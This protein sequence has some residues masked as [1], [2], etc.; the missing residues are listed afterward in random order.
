MV[1]VCRWVCL[2]W[3]CAPAALST[4]YFESSELCLTAPFRFQGW[5]LASWMSG[6][7]S[8]PISD[9]WASKCSVCGYALWLLVCLCSGQSGWWYCRVDYCLNWTVGRS[10]FDLVCQRFVHL[11]YSSYRFLLN[12]LALHQNGLVSEHSN[13]KGPRNETVRATR[14]STASYRT[15]ASKSAISVSVWAYSVLIQNMVV[16]SFPSLSVSGVSD[17]EYWRWSTLVDLPC[18]W[19]LVLAPLSTCSWDYSPTFVWSIYSST[20]PCSCRSSLLI[21]RSSRSISFDCLCSPA[22]SVSDLLLHIEKH[23]TSALSLYPP[24][25]S[26]SVAGVDWPSLPFPY[27]SGLSVSQY[28]PHHI[29]P[30]TICS[31]SLESSAS[32]SFQEVEPFDHHQVVSVLPPASSSIVCSQLRDCWW[33]AIDSPSISSVV[34]ADH[35]SESLMPTHLGLRSRANLWASSSEWIVPRFARNSYSFHFV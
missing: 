30:T 22:D 15:S 8:W 4:S 16:C 17:S 12:L 9:S 10:S 31:A 28:V 35:L 25:L 32:P 5:W 26:L 23:N 34:S 7:C 11:Q 24:V 18:S 6:W 3:D 1:D 29:A 20:S 13:W 33:S 21:W 14:W 2:R 19:S 27:T